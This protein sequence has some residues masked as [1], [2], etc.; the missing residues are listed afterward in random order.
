[1]ARVVSVD[2]SH[3]ADG[4]TRNFVVLQNEDGSKNRVEVGE[5]EAKR[6][7]ESLGGQG[8]QRLLTETLP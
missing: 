6:F 7:R 4:K 1:M 5:E 3:E 8:G 2:K